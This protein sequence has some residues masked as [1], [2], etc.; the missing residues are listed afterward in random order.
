M[1][2]AWQFATFSLVFFAVFGLL[3]WAQS[4]TTSIR[5]TVTDQTGAAVSNAKVTISN[6]EKALERDTTTSPTGEY[7]F[8]QLAPGTY[9]LA[10]EM[11]GFRS[12]Q[13]KDVQ[14]L[15]N[16]PATL[17]VTL[18]VGTASEVVE[19]LA[20]KALVNTTDASLGIAFNERQVR[21]LPL[22][23][24]SVPELL[25]LQ[26]GVTYTG[27]RSDVNRDVDTR[28]GA[29]NGARSDQSNITL[30]GVDVNDQVRGSAFTSVLPV[31]LDSVQEFRVTTTNYNADQGRSS[32]AQVSL[33]TKSGTNNFH[34]SLYEY[35]RNTYTSANDYF[36]KVAE[37]SSG[38]PNIPPKLIRN[39]FGGSLGGPI[40]KNRLFFFVNYEGARQ[41]EENSVLRIVPSDSLRLGNMRYVC[42]TTDPNCAPGT[43]NG[44]TVVND[45]NLGLIA[46]LTPTQIQQMDPLHIGNNPVV[47]RAL[48]ATAYSGAAPYETMLIRASRTFRGPHRCRRLRIS[49]RASRWATRHC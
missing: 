26:S 46:T 21:E 31:T 35:H 19:V 27:N 5:G 38:Q 33:V 42:D 6:L 47:S 39:I 16:S 15:V 34:G 14:L 4:S 32:G 22:E 23:G 41:R 12:N 20:E 10:V 8:L 37:L 43:H 44:V 7:E 24:R 9:Q 18:A 49:A 45:P 13:Q 30:D 29:V 3:S 17:N 1:R 2:S 25:S 28:S 48:G 11:T 40:L 36:V